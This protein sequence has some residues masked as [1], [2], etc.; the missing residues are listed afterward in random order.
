[1]ALDDLK[2]AMVDRYKHQ[3]NEEKRSKYLELTQS[4]QRAQVAQEK[5]MIASLM[6][7]L[8]ALNYVAPVEVSPSPIVV[9]LES[10]QTQV[11]E[12]HSRYEERERQLL[13]ADDVE[14]SM[15]CEVDRL[16]LLSLCRVF[17]VTV[18]LPQGMTKAESKTLDDLKRE[19][20]TLKE[21]IVVL[22]I[23]KVLSHTSPV[24]SP[25]RPSLSLSPSLPLSLPLPGA[26]HRS[27]GN[28]YCKIGAK[29]WHWTAG[30]P[31]SL[32]DDTHELNLSDA[33]CPICGAR[34]ESR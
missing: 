3:S 7:D 2:K 14:A 12:L 8:K 31:L 24:T 27:N 9:S 17:G 34:C 13:E 30:T 5:K 11:K 19:V 20:S 10:I 4:L 15:L 33:T 6:K 22:K 25:Y 16:N 26:S 28:H 18:D 29:G 21:D 23:T 1:L 32:S